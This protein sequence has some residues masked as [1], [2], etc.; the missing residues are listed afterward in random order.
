M[1]DDESHSD[2][3]A[4][5]SSGE[6]VETTGLIATREK[7]ATAGNL[8]GSLRAEI[9]E[10]DALRDIF[11]EDEEEDEGDYEG[12]DSG[13][14]D[15]AL[16]SSSDEEDTGPPQEGQAE[17]LTG[18]QELKKA[19]R[20]QLRQ[21]R[22]VQ[23]A[24]LKL[25]AWQKKKTVKLA[26]DVKTEDGAPAKPK[27]QSER[28]NWL[29]TK[30]D[31]PQR[32][33]RRS[34]AVVNR[35]TV[36]ANLK[37]AHERSEKQR[38]VMKKAAERQNHKKRAQ[39]SQEDR[40]KLCGKIA[41]QTDKDLVR[42]MERE[43]E[44]KKLKDEAL[45]A[46]WKRDIDGPYIRYWSGSVIWK[47][48]KLERKRVLHGSMDVTSIIDE[49]K[50]PLIGLVEEAEK[51]SDG[52]TTAH[53]SQSQD[54]IGASK[55][56]TSTS[57]PIAIQ[58][59]PAPVAPW[60][61][62][63][64][65]YASEAGPSNVVVQPGPSPVSIA[66]APQIQHIPITSAPAMPTP[67]TAPGVQPLT[68]AGAPVHNYTGWP[69]GSQQFNSQ[70]PPPPAVAREQA[71]R[72]LIMLEQFENLHSTTSKRKNQSNGVTS[73]DI[74][75]ILIPNA[76]PPFTDPELRYL[77][78]KHST[79]R[80]APTASTI[81]AVPEKEK[82]AIIPSKVAMYK[83]PKTGLPYL[84]LQCYKIIQRV[85]AGGCQWSPLLG[86]WVGPAYG[87]LG[88]PAVGVPAGFSAPVGGQV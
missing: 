12:S 37:H 57:I 85:L 63:I 31:A 64:H 77:L 27:K 35:E 43:K 38:N 84:D 75:S 49:P 17:D 82:C 71:Q 61:S 36:H 33:S 81:P 86:A 32:Q 4:S 18:E 45:A 55:E 1:S 7:R 51:Q 56:F 2:S 40:M 69:P 3:N 30:A 20:V 67:S 13:D 60:L 62:G 74:S 22:K 65:E 14:D 42:W 44:A 52:V 76:H 48:D 83:D 46:R 50:K 66:T 39:L 34:L 72:T 11:L 8:Y 80:T 16:E 78:T 70:L 28:S 73:T 29:P 9:D 79:R 53:Q 6:D 88:R 87:V 21:K 47:G 26:D 10:D 59:P 23:E 58:T 25:P 19:E 15:A 5:S 41:R 24:R 68:P 54:N